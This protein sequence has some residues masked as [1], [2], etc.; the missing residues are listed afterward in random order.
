[1]N[2][3]ILALTASMATVLEENIYPL[4]CLQAHPLTGGLA[5]GFVTCQALWMATNT[6]EIQLTVNLTTASAIA[7]TCIHE[8]GGFIDAVSRDVLVITKGNRKDPRYGLYFGTRSPTDTKRLVLKSKLERLRGWVPS[9]KASSSAALVA[10]GEKLEEKL[11][12]TDA[13]LAS[14]AV[15]EQAIRDF[16]AVGER[17]ALID[18]C[19]ALRKATY[20]ALSEMPHA[21]PEEQLPN[22]FAEQF[23]RHDTSRRAAKKLKTS[24]AIAAQLEAKDAEI[25]E[26]KEKLTKALADEAE[27][28][29]AKAQAEADK[30]AI[31]EAKKAAAEAEAKL[32]ALEAKLGL[33]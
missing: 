21:H 7:T 15:A 13:A 22:T 27:A 26:L 33:D 5:A 3:S 18:H 20:G 23:F 25:A 10:R 31:A 14:V 16:R 32:A 8:L 2:V 28:A 12:A 30:Q 11:T 29:K 17:R 1:M 4:A 6:K 9:L 24:A 19:N